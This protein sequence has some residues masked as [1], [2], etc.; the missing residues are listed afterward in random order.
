M[1]AAGLGANPPA[2]CNM[3]CLYILVFWNPLCSN[4][5]VVGNVRRYPCDLKLFEGTWQMLS[6][7]LEV[8]WLRVGPKCNVTA[9]FRGIRL[10]RG[11][12][13]GKD[14]RWQVAGKFQKEQE[15][16]DTPKAH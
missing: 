3:Q 11:P 8:S 4:S 10:G 15:R 9:V 2:S 5:K 16:K 7:Y 12:A 14:L 1:E 13:M 6:R